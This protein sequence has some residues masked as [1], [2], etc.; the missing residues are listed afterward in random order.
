MQEKT[1]SE[2]SYLLALGVKVAQA[3]FSSRIDEA[4]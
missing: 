1:A 3:T 2:F 4:A